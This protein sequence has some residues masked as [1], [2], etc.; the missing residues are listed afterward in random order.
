MG[1]LLTLSLAAPGTVLAYGKE[2]AIRDCENRIRGEYNLT[3]LR[4]AQAT[5]L[6]GEKHFRVAGKAKVDGDKHSW[7]CEVKNRHVTTAEYSG[8]KPKGMGTAEKLAIGTAAAVAIGVAASQAGKHQNDD[9][10]TEHNQH[11]G[12]SGSGA[13]ALQDLVGAKAS[14]GEMEMEGRGYEYASGS[15]GGGSS[16]TN[17]VKGSHCVTIRTENG[18]YQSIVDVT[19]LDCE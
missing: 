11:S 15:K 17:W 14:S 1:V 13:T 4:D 7:S 2:D 12:H 8:P 16:Y 19:M 9:G 3:D 10:Y 18:R 6:D 5:Q